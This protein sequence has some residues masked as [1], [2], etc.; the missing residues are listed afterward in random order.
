MQILNT[1]GI[2]NLTIPN[3]E[4]FEI[5]ILEGLI[6]NGPVFKGLGFSYGFSPNH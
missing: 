5:Q 6:S 4:T 2:L 1:V 3:P